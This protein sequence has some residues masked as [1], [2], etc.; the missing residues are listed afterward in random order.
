MATR[1]TA[2]F[3]KVRDAIQRAAARVQ[4]ACVVAKYRAAARGGR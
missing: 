4:K 1:T 2:K 3:V